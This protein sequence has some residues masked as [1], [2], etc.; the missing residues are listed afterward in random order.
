[1]L[2]RTCA[3][4]TALSWPSTTLRPPIR[5][6]HRTH[7][8]HQHRI[9]S[10]SIAARGG[11]AASAAGQHAA[12]EQQQL[13]ALLADAHAHPQLDPANMHRVMELQCCHV[14]AMS[15]S[16]DV[17]WEIMLQLQ[18]MAGRCTNCS[19]AVARSMHV[20][21]T[22]SKL[23]MFNKRSM[24]NQHSKLNISTSAAFRLVQAANSISTTAS[25]GKLAVLVHSLAVLHAAL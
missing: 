3:G 25:S 1:M 4:V 21:C 6:K 10:I 8:I 23:H 19:A 11:M 18:Q 16:Y 24:F 5:H 2:R 14:A 7:R 9:N 12:A 22:D 13:M 20:P 15:V 17:D